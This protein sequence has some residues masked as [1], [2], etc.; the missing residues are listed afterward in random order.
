MDGGDGGRCSHANSLLIRIQPLGTPSG[1]YLHYNNP[2]LFKYRGQSVF[3]H[4]LP[5][6][7]KEKQFPLLRMY[8]A[9]RSLKSAFVFI[10]IFFPKYFAQYFEH[11]SF[12][13]YLINE[14]M[15][16]LM[17]G[18]AAISGALTQLSQLNVFGETGV[19]I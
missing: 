15:N 6:A 17:N 11:C 4:I 12:N 7:M 16:T 5:A 18:K 10:F 19:F 14:R 9:T 13:H 3:F 1:L 2:Q 8:Y